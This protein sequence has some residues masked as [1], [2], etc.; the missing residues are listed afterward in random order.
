MSDVLQGLGHWLQVWAPITARAIVEIFILFLFVYGFLR[1]MQGTR[2]A[3]V[4]KGLAL[5][6]AILAGITMFLTG[7]LHLEHINWVITSLAPVIL[8]PLFI[9]FQPEVRRGLIRLGQN[10]LLRMFF[11]P[12]SRFIDELVN[13]TFGLAR[14]RIGGLI[15]LER[16]VG[17]RGLT[18]GG[19]RLDSEMSAELIRTIFWPGTPLHDGAVLIR[20]QRV[21]AAG[22][23]LPLTD[24]P[25]FSS[26]LGTR[27]RAAIGI[28]EESDA[29]AIVISEQTGQVA[30]AVAGQLRRDIDEASLRRALEE[31]TAEPVEPTGAQG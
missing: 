11:R 6:V 26:E 16:N 15:V 7:K 28:T 4:L 23:V 31:L 17:L 5:F 1:V 20:H 13:A 25:E 24:D 19:V 14:H 8:I 12:Q 18:E 29:A 27:H 2:G 22:C 21:A 3:G 30:L 10:P 9:L